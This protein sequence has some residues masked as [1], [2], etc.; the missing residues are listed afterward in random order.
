[1]LG[2]GHALP[3]R[4]TWRPSGRTAPARAGQPRRLSRHAHH[5]QP[6]TTHD[7]RG[8]LRYCRVP[9]LRT[10]WLEQE[11]FDIVTK[12]HDSVT[13]EDEMLPLLQ[14]LLAER[15]LR[16]AWRDQATPRLRSESRNERPEVRGCRCRRHG[17]AVLKGQ[18]IRRSA[19]PLRALDHTAVRGDTLASPGLSGAG[20]DRVSGAL[21]LECR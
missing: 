1:M 5:P 18:Q 2:S 17:P 7:C 21:T 11:R 16:N 12:T 14:P 6:P 9:D 15:S 10:Q 19:H 20:Y 8:C 13:G 3:E 4:S